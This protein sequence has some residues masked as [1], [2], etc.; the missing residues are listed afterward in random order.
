MATRR[1]NRRAVKKEGYAS[2]FEHEIAA[3]LDKAGIK[4]DYELYSFKWVENLP[5][6]YCPHCGMKPGVADRSY[7][8]DFFVYN[9][10]GT[11]LDYIIEAK[12]I[13]TAKD[14]KIADAMQK[15]YPGTQFKYLFYFDNKLSR[16]SKTRYSAW[17]EKRGLEYGLRKSMDA[18]LLNWKRA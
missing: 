5:N 3:A 11:G 13:F 15:T 18:T 16:S 14:R 9:E 6:S 4:Y 2:K 10:D 1:N 12:G 17:C 7:T 8:P